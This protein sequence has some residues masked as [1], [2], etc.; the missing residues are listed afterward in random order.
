VEGGLR[1]SQRRHV[2]ID[3]QEIATEGATTTFCAGFCACAN[4]RLLTALRR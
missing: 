2:T 3:H 4:P 1:F